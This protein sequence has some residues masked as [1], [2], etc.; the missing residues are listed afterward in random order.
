MEMPG[1]K[2]IPL[3]L[4]IKAPGHCTFPNVI[5]PIRDLVLVLVFVCISHPDPISLCKKKK[6]RSYSLF[7]Q[8]LQVDF[9]IV[10]SVCTPFQQL[11]DPLT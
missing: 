5:M 8:S 10:K 9:N 4:N 6:I 3:G 2:F 7:R 1:L 11:T